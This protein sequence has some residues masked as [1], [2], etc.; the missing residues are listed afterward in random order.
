[1]ISYYIEPYNIN[2]IIPGYTYDHKGYDHVLMYLT[3]S[4]DFRKGDIDESLIAYKLLQNLGGP[5]LSIL[6]I[7][8]I[9]S[10]VRFGTIQFH[11]Y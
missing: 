9:G 8:S 5:F 4:N 2:Y 1:M 3:T 10:L 6:L 7:S 11:Y